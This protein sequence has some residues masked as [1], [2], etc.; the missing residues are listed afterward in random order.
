MP[1]SFLTA[2]SQ[3]FH[4]SKP[5]RFYTRKK[6]GFD[7]QILNDF[8]TD[9]YVQLIGFG[10]FTKLNIPAGDFGGCVMPVMLFFISLTLIWG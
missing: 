5:V 9:F 4:S 7:Y 6:N 1:G 8:L 10:D 2:Q 3:A